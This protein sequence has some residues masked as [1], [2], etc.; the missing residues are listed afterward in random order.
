MNDMKPKIGIGYRVGKLTVK[1]ATEER[2]GGY[3]VWRCACGCGGELFLDT[4]Y[5]KRGTVTHCGCETSVVP[6]IRNLMGRRFGRLVAVEPTQKRVR[7][8]VV[9]KC[10]CDCGNETEAD[11]GQLL[12]GY[13]KS[14]GCLGHPPLKDYIGKRFGMLTVTEYAGKR[15]GMHRWKCVC[16]CGKETVV[17][18]TLL[19]T[20]KTKTC[21]CL[22]NSVILENLKLY[23]G[24][25]VAII[26]HYKKHLSASNKS[27]YNGVY[28]H[29]KS[30]KWCAQITF[31]GKT[32]FLGSYASIADAVKARQRADEEID[33]F[34]EQYYAEH[35]MSVQGKF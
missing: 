8:R 5:L 19:Q 35:G 18:Q 25:S 16:D 12:A 30:G 27:G 4:R 20:G 34:L 26:E 7:G 33:A 28:Q 6:E 2:R 22:Q 24:S 10:L 9:W 29:K 11:S 17:G 23:E 31:K 15:A 21:G 32:R 3:T 1:E 13:K 14:C